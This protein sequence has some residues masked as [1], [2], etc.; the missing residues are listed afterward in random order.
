MFRYI[1][2]RILITIP[3]LIVG[4]FLVFA[5]VQGMGD[6][7]G[8]WKLQKPREPDEIALAYERIGYNDP[9]LER[10]VN[11][12]GGFVQGD[13]GTTIIPG[14]G[15][16]DVQ[17]EV[18]HGLWTTFRLVIGAEILALLIGMAVGVIGA[19]RQY[20]IFDYT[21][22]GV[23]FALFSMPVFCIGLILKSA[24][25]PFN[26]FLESIGMDRWI[27]TAGPPPGGFSGSF[28][29]QITQYIGTFLLPTLALL[30]IQFALYSRFQRAS[31]LDVLGQD[32]VRTAQAKG[33]SSGRVIFRHA[34]RNGLIPVLTVFAVNFG[35]V[36]GG[37]VITETVF[38]WSGMGRLLIRSI[39]EK[40]V[41]MVLGVVMVTAVIVV[42][43]NLI[44]DIL[45][46]RLDPRIR[47]G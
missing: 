30:A 22:T 24:A 4:S 13:W 29:H 1:V 31:M 33:L 20:S 35:S 21:A 37:A 36:M 7:L 12:V 6:P 42:I 3:L 2:R 46:A 10:Y 38:N 41:F 16:K 15:V 43:A 39:Y 47:L 23:A 11:W 28:G 34:F 25:I 9:F 17:D 14:S 45:Y 5:L 44:A 19:V 27:T 32:Y 8:E 18:F 40:E 26:N